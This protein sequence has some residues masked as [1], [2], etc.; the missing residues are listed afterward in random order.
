MGTDMTSVMNAY[1]GL[2]R[3]NATMLDNLKV[4][5]RHHCRL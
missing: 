4:G 1:M 2:A 5:K 3:G